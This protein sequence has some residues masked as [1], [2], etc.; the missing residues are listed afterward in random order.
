METVSAI[1]A[2][3]AKATRFEDLPAGTVQQA[4]KVFLDLIGVSLA[5]YQSMAFP[6]MVVDYVVSLGGRAEATVIHG[7]KKI[8]AIH[9]AFANA[10]CAHAVDMDGLGARGQAVQVEINRDAVRALG[11]RGGAYRLA[12]LVDE[13]RAG[14]GHAMVVRM[15]RTGR[16]HCTG[17]ERKGL[18]F[19]H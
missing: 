8:P 2:D 17:C 5:G 6:K 16:Q 9:A 3:F 11:E 4:K 14:L 12:L 7:K 13:I 10:S 15:N 1:Y 19:A 18:E